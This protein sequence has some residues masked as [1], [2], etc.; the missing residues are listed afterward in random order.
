MS[1]STKEPIAAAETE[2]ASDKVDFSRVRNILKSLAQTVT[3]LKLYPAGHDHVRRY[4]DELFGR[5]D[6]FLGQDRPLE[7]GVLENA[8]THLGRIVYKDDNVQKS[9]P[10][11]FFQD[12]LLKLS[13]LPGLTPA[14]LQDF[15]ALI[16]DA[17]QQASGSQD[18]VDLLWQKEIEHIRF[19]APNEFL[20]SKMAVGTT[21]PLDFSVD[22][23]VLMEGTIGLMPEDRPVPPSAAAAVGVREP[24][25]VYG[26][27]ADEA[28]A[29]E[30]ETALTALLESERRVPVERD[31]FDT[32]SELLRL[33]DRPGSFAE[34]LEYLAQY[35]DRLIQ[36][37]HF[38]SALLLWDE[39]AEL[40][41]DLQDVQPEKS[42]ALGALEERFKG[43]ASPE[44]LRAVARQGLLW[45]YP[46]FF[47]FLERVGPA[48][49]ALA[50]DLYESSEDHSFRAP[51][52]AFFARMGRIDPALL[53]ALADPG[54][55]A[56]ARAILAALAG[57]S[58]RR[59]LPHLAAFSSHPDVS[60]RRAVVQT[61]RAFP[62]REAR[63]ILVGFLEDPDRSLRLEAVLALRRDAGPETAPAFLRLA[64]SPEFRDRD[65]EEIAAVLD[66][67]GATKTGEALVF[68]GGWIAKRRW[69]MSEKT[70]VL[71]LAAVRGLERMGT[72]EAE[73]VLGAGARRRNR[74][75]RA[76]CRAARARL[77]GGTDPGRGA[78]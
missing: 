44:A 7:L 28:A 4:R 59:V 1:P 76:A 29:E 72:P 21:M 63:R 53:A 23:R 65:P 38:S 17:F 55:P 49:L 13:F 52:E 32:M 42:S 62:G 46:P 34:T 67:L 48:T 35:H 57:Q 54:K 73:A 24:E 18:V 15:L 51:A 68:L 61:A 47:A 5:L 41:G 60:V 75:L 69:R 6:E 19:F 27:P 50:G 43:Q 31:F 14:D 37:A 56:L 10:Y 78:I 64:E 74:R 26:E 66:A 70:L 3:I 36:M 77:T 58:D 71:A 16:R 45:D 39:M 12:G 9:L 30:D 33:E 11:F 20:T 25:A 22:P 8:F 2:S 40:A